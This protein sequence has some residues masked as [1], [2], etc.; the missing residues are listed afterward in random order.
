MYIFPTDILF[1][2]K[3]K[4]QMLQT[5]INGDWINHTSHFS[6]SYQPYEFITDYTV[7]VKKYDSVGQD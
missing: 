2:N 6:G 4:D 1:T 7:T 3:H 5:A